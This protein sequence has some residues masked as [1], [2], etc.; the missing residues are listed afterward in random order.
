MFVGSREP[1]Y[2]LMTLEVLKLALVGK[3]PSAECPAGIQAPPD[4]D[5]L[6]A[7]KL[8]GTILQHCPGRVSC[9]QGMLRGRENGHVLMITR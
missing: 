7:P 6:P 5:V 4:E 8:L 9:L 1:H 2:I 3:P